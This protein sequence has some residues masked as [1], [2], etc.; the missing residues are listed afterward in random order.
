MLKTHFSAFALALL[1]CGVLG[2]QSAER[3]VLA[4]AGGTASITGYT[5]A[6]TLGE[7]FVQTHY[8]TGCVVVLTE[9]FQQSAP[10]PG[11]LCPTVVGVEGPTDGGLITVFPNPAE[12]T[13]TIDLGRPP[14]AAPLRAVLTDV[15][16][17][18][19]RTVALTE[20][21]ATLDLSG[22]PAALYILS[23]TD[24]NGWARA[25]Q[26]VKQ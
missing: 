1:T 6:W 11:F 22:L 12:S 18:T 13:V 8:D 26:V 15:A 19:L 5:V 9:G 17:R 7:A 2:A 20:Q 4:N 14:A 25:V 21:T 3:E 24:G 16:G 23:L 10:A